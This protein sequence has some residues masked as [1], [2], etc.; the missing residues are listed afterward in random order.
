MDWTFKS[1]LIVDEHD[2]W[3]DSVKKLFN[4]LIGICPVFPEI[5]QHSNDY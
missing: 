1:K 2:K 5:Y 4:K 3:I